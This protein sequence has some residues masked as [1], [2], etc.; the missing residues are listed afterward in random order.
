MALKLKSFP[1]NKGAIAVLWQPAVDNFPVRKPWRTPCLTLIQGF[2]LDNKLYLTAYF[3]S[4]DM[5]AAWPQNAFALRKLQTEIANKLSFGVGDLIT[6]SHTA[7]I[8]ENNLVSA[9]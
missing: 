8:D 5:F 2:C 6:I 4:N 9:E 3:R 1:Y 7:F